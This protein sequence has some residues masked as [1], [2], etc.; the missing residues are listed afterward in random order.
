AIEE[1]ETTWMELN[2]QLEEMIEESEQA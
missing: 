2:E 1:A